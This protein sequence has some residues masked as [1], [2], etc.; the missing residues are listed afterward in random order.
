[1]TEG[2]TLSMPNGRALASFAVK[3]QVDRAANRWLGGHG[4]RAIGAVAYSPTT[5]TVKRP[6]PGPSVGV[7]T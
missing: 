7:L 4:M 1:M 6:A 3:C 2:F 5:T